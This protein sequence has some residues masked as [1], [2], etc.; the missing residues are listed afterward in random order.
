MLTNP[1]SYGRHEEKY[2]GTR[3]VM[4]L[5]AVLASLQAPATGH[6]ETNDVTL[7]PMGSEWRYL[8]DGSNQ[9][10]NWSASGFDDSGWTSGYAQLGYGDGDETTVVD[11]GPQWWNKYITT[12]FRRTF[13]VSDTNVIFDFALSVIRDDGV[14][15][16][17]NGNN[18]LQS[19]ISSPVDYLKL[20]SS[21]VNGS[22]E[23]T[24]V[25]QDVPAGLVTEGT[26]VIAVEIHQRRARD[27][28]ISFDLSLTAQT[29]SAVS[30]VVFSEHGDT[31]PAVGTNTYLPG[32]E[33]GCFVTESP[34]TLS[35]STQLV[36]TGWTGTGSVT[37]GSGTNTTVQLT[38]DSTITWQWTTNAFWLDAESSPGGVVVGGDRW[39]SAG[40]TSV[41]SAVALD[42]HVFTHWTGDT[43]GIDESNA[44]A[45]VA[46]DRAKSLTAVFEVD[47]VAG[48]VRTPFVEFYV[49]SVVDRLNVTNQVTPLAGPVS[50]NFVG[51]ATVPSSNTVL[52]LLNDPPS[53]QVYGIDG[54]YS[55]RTISLSGFSDPE[56]ICVVDAETGLFALVE[57]ATN[58]I[59]IVTITPAT[60]NLVKGDAEVVPMDLDFDTGYESGIEGIAY[61]ATNNGF[62]AV[63]EKQPMAIYWVPRQAGEGP[64]AFE[65]FDAETSL[66]ATCSDLSDV[67]YDPYSGRLFFL[68]SDTPR[69]VECDIHGNVQGTGDIST[70]SPEGI[71]LSD[72]PFRAYVVSPDGGYR[73]FS[74]DTPA[75]IGEEGSQD[76]IEVRLS[77]PLTNTVSVDFEIVSDTAIAGSDYSPSNGTLTFIAGATNAFI[78]ID[79]LGDLET[80][81]AELL[82][83]S[84]TNAVDSQ[85]GREPTYEY[86]IA[87]NATVEYVVTSEHGGTVPSAGTNLVT[88]GIEVYF[89]VTNSPIYLPGGT[90]QYVCTGWTGTGSI[91]D[92]SGTE[93]SQVITENSSIIWI[94]QTN[95][96]LAVDSSEGGEVFGGNEWLANGSSARVDAVT[97]QDRHF[98]GWTGDVPPSLTNERPLWLVMDLARSIQAVFEVNTSTNGT[99]VYPVVAFSSTSQVDRLELLLS[100]TDLGGPVYDNISG[101]CLG[102]GTNEIIMVSNRGNLS[103]DPP[104]IQIYDLDGNYKTNISMVGFD[105]TEGICRY[106]PAQDLY[107]ILEEALNEIT[108]VTITQSTTS[109]NKADGETI[110]MGLSYPDPNKGVEGIFYDATNNCFYS[111]KE[112][113]DME[114][115]RVSL[116]TN[117][118]TTEELFDAESVFGGLATDLSDV[119]YNPKS[120]LLYILSDEG[121]RIFECDLS[122][123]ILSSFPLTATQPE[124]ITLS[125]DMS[126]LYVVGEPNEYFR[127]KLQPQS[128]SGQ[129]GA[130]FDMTV[131][132]SWQWTN[133]VSVEYAITSSD[134]EV[135]PNADFEPATGTVVFAAGSTTQVVSISVPLDE[136]SEADEILDVHL[137]NTV[138][139]TLDQNRFYEYT[140]LGNTA[141]SLV[142]RSI[143]GE[144]TPPPGTNVFNAGMIVP[145]RITNS[146]VD[147]GTLA[148][149]YVCVGWSGSN[150]VS[151]GGSD[152]NAGN[153]FLT[154]NSSITWLWNTNMYLDV[155]WTGSGTV[156]KASGWYAGESNIV[157]TAQPTTYHHFVSWTGDLAAEDTNDPQVTVAMD[158]PRSLSAD[159]TANMATNGTPEW[160]LAKYHWHTNDFDALALGDIDGDGMP[161]WEEHVADTIPND[162][163]SR[164]AVTYL[165]IGETNA[166]LEWL[167]VTTRQYSVY[168]SL[169]LV[170]GWDQSPLASNLWGH[171]SGTNVFTDTNAIEGASYQIRTTR[172]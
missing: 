79:I 113:G 33:V 160:W 3:F 63:K 60:T 93:T 156:D 147:V 171:A 169:D 40:S 151:A 73:E 137:T 111:V 10:T 53:I 41:I 85:V 158:Q 26:N 132:L 143:H 14:V 146:P 134:P 52:V 131:Q 45:S 124:G 44:T 82:V 90:T 116:D 46:M 24:P 86:T 16:Y 29:T 149:Q 21:T 9:G 32:A 81:G 135:T 107:A 64:A 153:I 138:N 55:G 152:T 87:G 35:G 94:W 19:N 104:V 148:T 119:A 103:L 120:G 68:C 165:Y 70:V 91:T 18:V 54:A 42:Y 15:V 13:E 95:V 88:A 25:E 170:T 78:T 123:N 139:S 145:C 99:L 34:L 69:I 38:N 164:L 75:T 71:S 126:E 157:V 129:E 101:C 83:L 133:T 115:Y 122:G 144:C 168:R 84:L 1:H 31:V 20:A 172:P 102:P 6:A 23:S 166:V 163:T 61:S 39:V 110:S 118:A 12:Y 142:V 77:W 98:A 56:G 150:D 127:Y 128:D 8:D 27:D 97:F 37:N 96:W 58:D 17:I 114:V 50:S 121:K 28:D 140:I 80:E 59:S 72:N 2:M 108:I 106:D 100:V 105:D 30:L 62:F 36:C 66:A 43:D 67:A 155:S 125:A 159:F 57:E 162:A 154:T 74:S 65:L 167:S 51:C 4:A 109:L 5:A 47:T 112:R 89:A 49:S 130:S 48:N 76:Q 11:Y 117:S 7:I 136:E 22:A 161:A 92:G 141:V